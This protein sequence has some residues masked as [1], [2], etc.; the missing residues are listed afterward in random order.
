MIAEALNKAVFGVIKRIRS[1]GALHALRWIRHHLY[2]RYREWSLGVETASFDPDL[3]ELEGNHH[4]EPLC[5]ECLDGALMELEIDP[6]VDVFLD[7]GAGKGRAVVAAAARPFRRVIGVEL[8][9]K[10]L[11][12]ARKNLGRANNRL[13][14]REIEL[15]AANAIDYPVPDDV[16]VVFLFNPFWGAVMD[17]VQDQLRCSLER[18]PRPLTI[19]YVYPTNRR[20]LFAPCRWLERT[21][22]LPEMWEV[23]S[24][25]VYR[26]HVSTRTPRRLVQVESSEAGVD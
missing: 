24:L 5:Y 21:R 25:S 16:T 6:D 11:E 13:R 1:R 23:L 10:L 12:V 2:E 18:A 17:A 3:P 7:Y 8:D 4:Y 14:C 15:V 19:L 20:D 9:H 22:Y 26:A